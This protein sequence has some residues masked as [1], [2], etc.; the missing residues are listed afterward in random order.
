MNMQK[1]I[2]QCRHS[3]F[4]S[5]CV[6]FLLLSRFLN[7]FL[8]AGESGEWRELRSTVIH[9][10]PRLLRGGILWKVDDVVLVAHLYS[11]LGYEQKICSSFLKVIGI[12]PCKE[13]GSSCGPSHLRCS[14]PT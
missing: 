13:V 3:W 2:I 14:C 11:L 12:W 10:H 8:I 5:S 1:N 7:G 6:L 4:F 9:A